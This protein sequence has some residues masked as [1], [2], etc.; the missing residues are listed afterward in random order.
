MCI[1]QADGVVITEVHIPIGRRLGLGRVAPAQG[2]AVGRRQLVGVAV[3]ATG[4]GNVAEREIVFHRK[5]VNVA[6]KAR[7]C[8]EH[9]E[10]GAKNEATVGQPRVVHGLDTHAVARKEQGLLVAVPQGK[11]EHAPQSVQAG[12]AP[13]LPGMHDHF[14]IAARPEAIAQNLEFGHQLAVVVDLTV[15]DNAH[16]T[17]FIE[18]GL[19]AGGQVDDGKAPMSQRQTGL[20]VHIVLIRPA[21]GLD[22][23]DA[24]NQITRVGARTLRI[25]KTGYATHGQSRPRVCLS[26]ATSASP[27]PSR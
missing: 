2:E 16:G 8:S 13:G 27:W 18:Q 5:R 22:I 17:V 20:Q 12:L 24:R 25:E 1:G 23:V 19:L 26:A 3:D 21:V 9:F 6:H 15:E 11:G 14:G 10:F 4:I 7:V